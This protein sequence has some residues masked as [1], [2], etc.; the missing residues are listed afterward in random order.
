[1]DLPA[2][3][4]GGRRTSY[5]LL[6]QFPDDPAA[7][8]VLQRQSSGGSSYGPGSSVSGSSDYPFN[9]HLPPATAAAGPAAAGTPKSWAQQAEETYQLQLAL[10]LRL[11]ADAACAADP[12][13]LDPGDAKMMGGPG[14]GGSGSGRAFP[15]APPT[16]TAE[17]LSHRFWVGLLTHTFLLPLASQLTA[18]CSVSSIE[19]LVTNMIGTLFIHHET[20]RDA[21]IN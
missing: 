11:C 21:I 2:A 10:A 8:A 12:G 9:H 20:M 4:G 18:S 3:T 7:P 17:A 14:P 6:S 16:P 5:S 15:L 19:C 1:M 13:F